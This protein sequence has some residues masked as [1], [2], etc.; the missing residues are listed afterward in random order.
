[1]FQEFDSSWGSSLVMTSLMDPPIIAHRI[2]VTP[3]LYITYPAL[4]MELI[5]KPFGNCMT[6]ISAL[7]GN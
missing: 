5:G 2:R 4:K 7:T 1:M 3:Q 6:R